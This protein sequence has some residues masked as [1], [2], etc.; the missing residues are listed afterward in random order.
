[1][2]ESNTLKGISASAG[3]VIG[4]AFI[5]SPE[6]IV[7]SKYSI[8]ISDVKNEITRFQIALKKT[9]QEI[10]VL[11]DK[12]GKEIGKVHANIFT[13]HLLILDD[14]MLTADTINEVKKSK[15][16]IEH[17]F[18][19]SLA[20]LTQMIE[21]VDDPYFKERGNDIKDV[22]RRVLKNLVGKNRETL[23]DLKEE[24]IVFAKDLSPSDTAT[25]HKEKVIGFAT[26]IGGKTSHTAIMARALQIPA[27]VGLGNVTEKVTEGDIVIVDGNRGI[28][29]INPDEETIKKYSIELEK[30]IAFEREL[31][32]LKDL[33]AQTKD[34]YLIKINA[35]IEIPEEIPLVHKHGAEGIGL[36]RTE[37]LY[38][39]KPNLPSEEEQFNAYRFVVEEMAPKPVILRTLDVG[40][41]KF[42]S[43]LN[44]AKEMNPFLGL[45]AIRLCLAHPDIFRVQLRAIL[46]ASA[47]G[48]LKIMFPMISSVEELKKAKEFLEEAKKELKTDGFA[49]D[50]NIEVGVMIEVPSAVLI[51]DILA[52][53]V[54]FFSIGTNDLIQYTLAID[55]INEN[56]AHLYNPLHPAILRSIKLIIDAAHKANIVV[57]MCG[58]M[59]G[60]SIY[61]SILL[62]LGLDSLSMSP[63]AIPEVKKIIRST[64]LRE[65][66]DYVGKIFAMSTADEVKKFV[67]SSITKRYTVVKEF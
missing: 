29:L 62:G 36:Y 12:L 13:A 44:L 46:R 11:K 42:L 48:K 25:M 58:E 51:A 24:V 60:D 20:K 67:N 47:Y 18:S 30:F 6:D 41:D 37:F 15:F 1:M 31:A 45:R 22:G 52:K 64:T 21:S 39:N 26:D 61:T 9:R 56:I 14:P 19:Q 27:V 8:D 32:N 4:K 2:N 34:D 59:A 63:I 53:E 10:I 16:N 54:S 65:A 33:K 40:G 5:Y 7:I 55:R 3:I 23:V 66:K 43:H 17:V 28:I 35:N 49:F 38:L 57:G 50:E